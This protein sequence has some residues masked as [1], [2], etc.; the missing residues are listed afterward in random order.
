MNQG[1]TVFAQLMELL[2]KYEF[3]KCVNR[4]GGHYKVQ[5]FSCWEQFLVMSFAQLTYRESL[6]DIEACLDAVKNK[7]YH[8]GIRSN[9]SR[10]TLADANVSR[11]WRIYA[12]FAK[13]L[14]AQARPLYV[15]DND[16]SLTLKNMV[17]AFDS[18]T[19]DLCLTL[20]P[21]AHFRKHK[22]AIKL[23]TLLDLRGS[24]P[25]FLEIT[26]GDV[27]DI[28]VLDLLIY[29][30]GA[31][32]VMDKGYLDYARLYAI[33]QAK[34]YFVTIAKQNFA[35]KRVYS[36]PVNKKRGIMCDQLVNFAGY[37]ANKDYSDKIRRIKYHD[38]EKAKT[39]TFLTNNRKLAAM[40]IAN[41]YKER[42]KVELF[43]RWMKQHLRIKAFYGT[44]SNAVYTQ[45][46]I[47]VSI[48]LLVAIMKKKMH[49]EKSIYTILQILSVSLFE[50]M[51][52]T[53]A[54]QDN[55]KINPSKQISNQ[56][57]IFE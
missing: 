21:W 6:R 5:R 52:I 39:F 36:N 24:I 44:T 23:H 49:I 7:L 16:F 29:E 56:L 37:Y 46:W 27:H 3:D 12:D 50:K 19:I 51:H 40:T 45:V 32:Y 57:S 53:E 17:Y 54:F 38:A 18:S 2:P 4:Y 33:E 22:A 47:A 42:W 1:K 25:T 9:V 43:F 10:S 41:L 34:A 31:F 15:E 11:D 26:N 48:Y 13:I 28:N 35:F 30:A 20:F 14:I 8:S 55:E